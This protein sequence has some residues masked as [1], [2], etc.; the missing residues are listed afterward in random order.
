MT[1]YPRTRPHQTQSHDRPDSRQSEGHIGAFA[2]LVKKS[3]Y[4]TGFSTSL[5]GRAVTLYET[6]CRDNAP[7]HASTSLPVSSISVRNAIYASA[8]VEPAEQ[9]ETRYEDTALLA[10]DRRRPPPSC[11]RAII[12]KHNYPPRIGVRLRPS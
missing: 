3:R 5:S 12:A 9:A 4:A 2:S 11:P 7:I 8:A 6:S 10:R 1:N